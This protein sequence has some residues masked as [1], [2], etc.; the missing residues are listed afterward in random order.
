MPVIDGRENGGITTGLGGKLGI[1]DVLDRAWSRSHVWVSVM[2]APLGVW[3]H[4]LELL[5]TARSLS[6]MVL[7]GPTLTVAQVS[8]PADRMAGRR[9]RAL[10]L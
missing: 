2:R 1:Y 9:F 4:S 5:S 7:Y 10:V 6:R 8:G 3:R